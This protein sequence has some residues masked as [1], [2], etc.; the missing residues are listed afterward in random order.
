MPVGVG[1]TWASG[2]GGFG[3]HLKAMSSHYYSVLL[4][5]RGKR[6]SVFTATHG[7]IR[8]IHI[9]SAIALTLR[10]S[11]HVSHLCYTGHKDFYNGATVKC[12]SFFFVM[13]VVEVAN[14]VLMWH[15]FISHQS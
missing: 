4:L 3:C 7:T 9:Q 1:F 13:G 12:N 10:W 14:A 11:P 5:F 8:K 6:S 15:C 2:G